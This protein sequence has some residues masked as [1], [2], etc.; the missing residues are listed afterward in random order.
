VKAGKYGK[1]KYTEDGID[2]CGK[3]TRDCTKKVKVLGLRIRL[4]QAWTKRAPDFGTR[5]TALR[6]G[7]RGPVARA[8]GKVWD[9][10]GIT[11]FTLIKN[12]GICKFHHLPLVP[13]CFRMDLIITGAISPE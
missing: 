8:A 10:Y 6:N 13:A 4:P 5:S 2:H 3:Y 11:A 9:L 7:K 12:C 1:K